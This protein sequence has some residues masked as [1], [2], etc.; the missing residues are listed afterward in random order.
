MNELVQKIHALRERSDEV[1]GN[2][3]RTDLE[4]AH[5]LYR[6]AM[7]CEDPDLFSKRLRAAQTALETVSKFMWKAN[8][9]PRELDQLTAQIERL[10]FQLERSDDKSHT[11]VLRA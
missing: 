11:I 6:L 9:T 1:M 4:L 7:S 3:L 5:T 10:K 8:L 2:F